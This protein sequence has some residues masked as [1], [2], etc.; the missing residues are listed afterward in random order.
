MHPIGCSLSP[1]LQRCWVVLSRRQSY[2]LNKDMS[3]SR[4]E[5]VSGELNGVI[6]NWTTTCTRSVRERESGTDCGEV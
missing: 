6:P 4:L 3:S 1:Q 5:P 2:A